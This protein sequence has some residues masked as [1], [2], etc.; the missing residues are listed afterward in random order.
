MST[1][2]LLRTSPQ[3]QDRYV[4]HVRENCPEVETYFPVYRKITRPARK[5]HPIPVTL[6]VFP[7]Y[8]FAHFDLANDSRVVRLLVSSP[9][10]AYFIRFGGEIGI[11][12]HAVIAELR[13]LE[14]LGQL[15]KE[16]ARR[17]PFRP[18]RPV[19]VHTPMYDIQAVIVRLMGGNR[20]IVDTPLGE[21]TVRIHSI[22]LR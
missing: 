3:S 22:T 20:V 8:V 2:A 7:G 4:E 14:S 12:P 9:V 15:I 19:M 17:N 5:R 21:A 18:G 6:P 16:Q 13:R 11:V 1:W 10:R